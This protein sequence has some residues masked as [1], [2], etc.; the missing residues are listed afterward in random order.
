MLALD[1]IT[2]DLL[3][4]LNLTNLTI[5]TLA[6]F[7]D[8][9]LV[10]IR[11]TMTNKEYRWACIPALISHVLNNYDVSSCT[12]LDSQLYFFNS[13]KSLIQ[14]SEKSSITLIANPANNAGNAVDALNRYPTQLITFKKDKPGLTAL[15]W[16]KEHRISWCLNYHDVGKRY[17]QQDLNDLVQQF[18]AIYIIDNPAYTINQSTIKQYTIFSECKLYAYNLQQ[19]PFEII[20]YNFDHLDANTKTINLNSYNLSTTAINHLY[21]PYLG[22]L[23]AISK[24]VKSLIKKEKIKQLSLSITDLPT[25][26]YTYKDALLSNLYK[27]L[28]SW[29]QIAI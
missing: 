21:K 12:Y 24:T 16:W 2:V 13:A 27:E 19:K 7:K 23:A 3:A 26:K 22:H 6:K 4:K 29:K 18:N 28:N 17:D 11:Q 14:E 25:Y 20:F 5:I 9:G 8:K 1:Q 10:S 15:K